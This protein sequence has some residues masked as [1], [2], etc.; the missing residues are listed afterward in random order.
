MGTNIIC[1]LNEIYKISYYILIKLSNNVDI[2]VS[3]ACTCRVWR[4]A[5]FVRSEF[6]YHHCRNLIQNFISVQ[7]T[8]IYKFFDFSHAFCASPI[9]PAERHLNLEVG[10]AEN[11]SEN[12]NSKSSQLQNWSSVTGDDREYVRN[13]KEG[14]PKYLKPATRAKG[15]AEGKEAE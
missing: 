15:T 13:G 2:N 12:L 7:S 1:L 10:A 14:S 11:N 6:N 8:I 9:L 3:R 5:V 4:V